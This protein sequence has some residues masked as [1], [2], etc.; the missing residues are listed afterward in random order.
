MVDGYRDGGAEFARQVGVKNLAD[1]CSS[2]GLR[3][4]PL[5]YAA[6]ELLA[7]SLLLV[8]LAWGSVLLFKRS[9]TLVLFSVLYVGLLTLWPFH[10]YR[11]LLALWP[12]L[13]VAGATAIV[14][15]LE[16]QARTPAQHGLRGVA[17]GAVGIVVVGHVGYNWHAYRESAWITLQ[18]RVGISAK[19]MVEWTLAHT[20][21]GDLIASHQDVLLYLYTGRQAI[22]PS[23]FL[24]RQRL[25]PFSAT[26]EAHWM[27]SI[28]GTYQPR[29]VVTGWPPHMAA[30]DLLTTGPAPML[31]RA[32][33]IPHHIVYERLTP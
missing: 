30:A 33:A 20:N 7:L 19:P 4:M 13:V 10:P 21:P 3:V 25:Q 28:I 15:L 31:R 9:P 8:M 17:L 18:E 2:L 1:I 6:L 22:P 26:E 5:E 12:A 14:A 27:G 11:F 24:P 29:F 23:T 16:W 32:G